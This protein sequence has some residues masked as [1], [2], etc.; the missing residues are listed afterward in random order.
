MQ[1]LIQEVTKL[2]VADRHNEPSTRL[3]NWITGR[4]IAYIHDVMI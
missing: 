4:N 1:A 2:F 3:L